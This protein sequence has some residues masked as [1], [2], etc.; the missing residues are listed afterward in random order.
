MNNLLS[1]KIGALIPTFENSAEIIALTSC[2]VAILLFGVCFIA[3]GYKWKLRRQNADM[4]LII[5]FFLWIINVI[6]RIIYENTSFVGVSTNSSINCSNFSCNTPQ[7]M[8]AFFIVIFNMISQL[9]M[10]LVTSMT[11]HRILNSSY[12]TRLLTWL[13]IAALFLTLCGGKLLSILLLLV[14][15]GS[16]SLSGYQYFSNVA[17]GLDSPISVWANST[18]S[19]LAL[20]TFVWNTIPM[21]I[22]LYQIA[23]SRSNRGLSAG[24]RAT[25]KIDPTRTIWYLDSVNATI[26]LLFYTISSVQSLTSMLGNDRT[27]LSVI[28]IKFA[29]VGFHCIV[30]YLFTERVREILASKVQKTRNPQ[31]P[32]KRATIVKSTSHNF[33]QPHSENGIAMID[34]TVPANPKDQD[35]NN[36]AI[37][38]NDKNEK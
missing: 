25:L 24:I 23:N 29:L 1:L 8:M 36:A 30:N 17:T 32:L 33:S 21:H 18:Y 35:I 2:I 3:A 11:L 9:L 37:V 13:L 16:S 7:D 6:F 10:I 19:Y 22:A 28:S 4:I 5:D 38:E 27:Q 14:A 34:M 26:I 15:D 20:F 12:Q 31:K